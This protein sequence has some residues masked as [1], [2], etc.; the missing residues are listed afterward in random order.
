M[1]FMIAIAVFVAAVAAAAA[2]VV[3]TK[4]DERGWQLRISPERQPLEQR[5]EWTKYTDAENS[6]GQDL[7]HN[8]QTGETVTVGRSKL[9]S[10]IVK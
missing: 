10:L 6:N 5:G 8:E 4:D 9:C 1:F 7:F 3:E 2:A